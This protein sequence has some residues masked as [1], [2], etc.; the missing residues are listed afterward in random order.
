MMVIGKIMKLVDMEC[1]LLLMVRYIRDSDKI[2]YSMV[3]ELKYN[4]MELHMMDNFLMDLNMD[5]A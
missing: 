5:R 3:K 1:L 2:M 4:L